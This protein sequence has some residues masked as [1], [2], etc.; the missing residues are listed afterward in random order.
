MGLGF[1]DGFKPKE[2]KV[3]RNTPEADYVMSHKVTTIEATRNE[4]TAIFGKPTTYADPDKVNL[5]WTLTFE[6]N[7]GSEVVATIYDWKHGWEPT[8]NE[9]L[10]WSVG[11]F[12]SLAGDYVKEFYDG[13]IE[14]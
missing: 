7:D 13:W 11:G 14:G 5:Q 9:R 8:E 6:C 12:T 3:C 4:L 2:M 1:G 10:E